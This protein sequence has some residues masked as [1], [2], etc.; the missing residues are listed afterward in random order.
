M[1]R[2]RQKRG[3]INFIGDIGSVLFGLSTEEQLG[4]VKDALTKI[5]KLSNNNLRKLNIF[6][7]VVK[8]EDERIIRMQRVQIKVSNNVARLQNNLRNATIKINILEQKIQLE[9]ILNN[10]GLNFLELQLNV[11]EITSG[12]RSMIR[13]KV[14]ENIVSSKFLLNVLKDIKEA[15]HNLILPNNDYKNSFYYYNSSK[16]IILRH[17]FTPSIT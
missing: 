14:D 1:T 16:Q 3:A 17:Y 7:A 9:H 2:T 12:L 10:L 13:G 4:E 5:D 11:N 8:I 6:K 15:G